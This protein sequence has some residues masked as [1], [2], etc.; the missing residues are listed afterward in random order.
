M[1]TRKLTTV[2]RLVPAAADAYEHWRAMAAVEG[3]DLV[4][5]SA[6]D[7]LRLYSVQDKIFRERYTTTVLAGRPYRTWNGVRWYQKPGTASA[8]V[9]GTG[10]HPKGIAIDIKSV[11]GFGS[12]YYKWLAK[13]GPKL[14]FS[15]T[16]GRSI[17]EPWH[18]VYKKPVKPVKHFALKITKRATYKYDKPGGKKIKKV[19]ALTIFKAIRDSRVTVDGQDWIKS[20]KGGWLPAVATKGKKA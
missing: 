13:T 8:A 6:A 1:R 4:P 10:N 16:E 9:P 18:W 2:G 3:Y 17:S 12:D 7:T 20:R 5:T 11:G 19:R 14:G 15:N